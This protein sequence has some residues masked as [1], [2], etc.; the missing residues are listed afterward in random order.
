MDLNFETPRIQDDSL[1][2]FLHAQDG[3]GS[4]LSCR[5]HSFYPYLQK[6]CN[7][8]NFKNLQDIS[9]LALFLEGSMPTAAIICELVIVSK[10]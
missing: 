1:Q 10:T 3:K 2:L 4:G 5:G 9:P 8:T 6:H 7:V